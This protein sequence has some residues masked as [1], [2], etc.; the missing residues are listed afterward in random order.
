VTNLFTAVFAG[1]AVFTVMGFL[2]AQQGVAVTEVVSEGPGLAFIVYP[3]AILRM[4]T[5]PQLW[6]V[7]FFFMLFVLGLG[8][9]VS[10]LAGNNFVTRLTAKATFWLVHHPAAPSM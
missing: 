8:S 5:M 1:F 4:P 10:C 7:L 3:E 2:A 6:A 9:Q